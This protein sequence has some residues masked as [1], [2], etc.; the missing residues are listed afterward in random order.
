MT[1]IS[2]IAIRKM[3]SEDIETL[4]KIYQE[5]YTNNYISFSE[6]SEGL[7]NTPHCISPNAIDIFRKNLIHNFKEN[8]SGYFI[9]H[10]ENKIT[11]FALASLHLTDGGLECWLDDLIVA[12]KYH[13]QGIGKKLIEEVIQW[14]QRQNASYFLL[15]SGIKNKSA[16]HFFE[17]MGFEPMAMVFWKKIP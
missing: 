4:S 13:R 5:N 17:D 12:K 16:H 11:G 3:I 6:L 15:E 9:A 10:I 8:Q 2:K 14:G 7:A 1:K